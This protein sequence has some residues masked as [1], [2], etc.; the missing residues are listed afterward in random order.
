MLF[1]ERLAKNFYKQKYVSADRFKQGIQPFYYYFLHYP[2][3]L[4]EEQVIRSHIWVNYILREELEYIRNNQDSFRCCIT[5]IEGVGKTMLGLEVAH[6]VRDW[7]GKNGRVHLVYGA[8]EFCRAFTEGRIQ[9]NDVIVVDEM[10]SRFEGEGSKKIQWRVENIKT[11]N[12][13]RRIH[14]VFI[15]T[16][17]LKYFSTLAEFKIIG[18]DPKRCETS[19][20]LILGGKLMGKCFLKIRDLE[21]YAKLEEEFKDAYIKRIEERGGAL[22]VQ[23]FEGGENTVKSTNIAET[24]SIREF[25]IANAEPDMKPIL[26]GVFEGK[27]QTAI[28]ADLAVTQY[29]I[30]YKIKHFGESR[31]G[32]IAEAFF[33][34]KYNDIRDLVG[35][36]PQGAPDVVGEDGTVLSVKCYLGYKNS[37]IIYPLKDCG[38]ELEYCRQNNIPEFQLVFVNPIWSDGYQS[39]KINGR[40]PPNYVSFFRSE[41]PKVG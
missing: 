11:V 33:R 12:R 29:A 13:K 6:L 22:T 1:S 7:D 23:Q 18:K 30:S 25:I 41:P 19:F 27:N 26:K 5:G 24:D 16:D 20:F 28:A 21:G 34:E 14:Y 8:D 17:M 36:A 9:N 15:S 37:Q 39:V 10:K 3:K 35:R 4:T 32:Y 2:V 38:P 40:E 31:L